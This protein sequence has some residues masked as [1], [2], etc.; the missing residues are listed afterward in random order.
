MMAFAFCQIITLPVCRTCLLNTHHHHYLECW[1]PKQF[2]MDFL[3]KKK[4]NNA[5]PPPPP[6]PTTTIFFTSCSLKLFHFSMTPPTPQVAPLT[7]RSCDV[8][9]IFIYR[10]YLNGKDFSSTLIDSVLG[11]VV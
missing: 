9:C 10:I 1:G 8:Q 2:N 6:L 4:K 3:C 7:S 5:P 11:Q